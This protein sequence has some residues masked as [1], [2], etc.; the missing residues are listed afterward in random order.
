MCCK[1]GITMDQSIGIIGG[2]DGPTEIFIASSTPNMINAFGLA[3]VL[4]LLIPNIIYAL[5]RRDEIPKGVGITPMGILE[6]IGRYGCML[7]MAVNIGLKEFGFA[8]VFG[9]LAY[10][11]GNGLFI[12]IYW[13]CWVFYYNRP[14]RGL[15]LMLAILPAAVFLL[16]GTVL[17][18]WLLVIA[19][20]IFAVSH[21]YITNQ[22]TK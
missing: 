3:L 14:T 18:H 8:S 10:L 20:V 16:S 15:A 5:A 7:L 22:N 6:Q 4:L 2:A 19:A 11:F 9:L 1:K 17:R 12:L 13:V 21:I